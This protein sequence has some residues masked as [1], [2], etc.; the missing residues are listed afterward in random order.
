MRCTNKIVMITGASSGIG[1]ASAEQFAREGAHLILCARR[2]DK[3]K[4]LADNLSQQ[5]AVK[6]LPFP[7]DVSEMDKIEK[8]IQK[9][10]S[11][12]KNV[13]I[14]VNNAG[15]ALGY[16]QMFNGKMEDWEQVI[17]VNIKGVLAMIRLIVPQ[18][19]ERQTGHIIN[20]GSISSRYVYGGGGVYCATKYAVRAMTESLKMEVHGTPIRVSLINP[21]M[22]KTEFFDV[23]FGGDPKKVEEMFANFTPLNPED[24]ADAIVYCVTRPLHVDVTELTLVPTYQTPG[25]GTYRKKD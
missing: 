21:G 22:V 25:L 23:R 24:V 9:L 11:F 15:M 1:R 3:L 17:N 5:F 13:D 16:D 2:E 4:E 12:W 6:T 20:L 10:S 14:L 7:V 19:I 8:Q 18:M